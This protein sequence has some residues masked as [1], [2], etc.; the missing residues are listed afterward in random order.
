MAAALAAAAFMVAALA[1]ADFT[2]A[3]LVAA[4]SVA[5]A[6]PRLAAS[7]AVNSAVFA[8]ADF[9][10]AASGT[11]TSRS[12]RGFYAYDYYDPYTYDD[13]Y[14]YYDDDD[15]SCY[16]VQRRVHTTHG[17]RLRPVQVCDC[18]TVAPRRESRH[19]LNICGQ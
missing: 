3:V 14:Y 13:S 6:W 12:V 19:A 11:A 9:M 1:A 18:W 10:I 8:A 2:E 5:A 17:W 16:V 15:G 4:V 7:T